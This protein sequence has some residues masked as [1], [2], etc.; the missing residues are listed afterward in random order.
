MDEAVAQ[1]TRAAATALRPQEKPAS[2]AQEVLAHINDGGRGTMRA[3]HPRPAVN[4]RGWLSPTRG[5][6]QW[7]NE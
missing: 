3:C 7:K 5:R 1:E 6:K 4:W 2:E